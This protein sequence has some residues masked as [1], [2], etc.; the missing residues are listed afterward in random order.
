[1]VI[2]CHFLMPLACVFHMML[3][4]IISGKPLWAN[5]TRKRFRLRILNTMYGSLMIIIS[6]IGGKLL[7]AK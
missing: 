5:R 6:I 2:T 4:V 3:K 7:R 1:M